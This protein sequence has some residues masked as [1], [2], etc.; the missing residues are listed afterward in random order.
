M[1]T[2]DRADLG[3]SAPLLR[4]AVALDDG[5]GA[6]ER[7][8]PCTSAPRG[9]RGRARRAPVADDVLTPGLEQLRVAAALP[10]LRRHRRCSTDGPQRARRCGSATAGTA[11]GSAG[12][13]G[14]ALYG[15]RARRSSPSWRS[16]RRRAPP[17]RRSPTSTWRAGPSDVARQRPLRRPDDRRAAARRRLAAARR[18]RP[19]GWTGVRGAATIDLRTAGPDVGP[20]VRRQET[21]R[22]ESDVDVAV[23]PH[24]RRLRPEPRRLA[25]LPR[26]RR[27]RRD[28][29]RPAR[30]GAR[31]RRAG[32]PAA[33]R[34]PR[35]PTRSSS[36]AADD[37]FE[38]TF[39]FH[40]FRYAEVDGWPGELTA[41]D[42]EAVV[43]HSDLRAHRHTSRAPTPLLN[44][45]HENVVWS[46]RGNFLDVPTDC[47]QRD[48]RL[49]WTGDIAVFAP[50]AAYLYDVRRLP[51]RLA[52]RPRRRAG[53]RRRARAV[54]RPRRAQVRQAAPRRTCPRRARRSGATPRSWVPWALWQAYGDRDRPGP[55]AP[56]RWL[57]HVR[58]VASPAVGHGPVGAP[59]SSSATGSTRTPRRTA[60]PRRR[61]T[62]PSSRPRA[63]TARARIVAE[64]AEVL[65]RAPRRGEFGDARASGP[66]A[67]FAEHYVD[68]D[69][70]IRSDCTDRLRARDRA[71]GCSTAT[72][73]PR[74]GDRLAELVAED[75]YRDR[76]RLRRHPVRPRRAHRHRARRRLAYRLLLQ[77]GVPVVALPG[78]DGRDDDL[79][80]V[81]LDAARRHASTPA[82]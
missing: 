75:G 31:G 35:R 6:V 10:H 5:H 29:H 42:V 57:A 30:R 44:R 71:S 67:A 59:A 37:A 27:A 48:E 39:T 26:P 28:D 43:V 49:G 41:D 45:L 17:G 18:R 51:R 61:P 14:R 70:A 4:T 24:A 13:G 68:A 9:V 62:R 32:H 77:T 54:R 16:L 46:M 34:R 65:G 64:A 66:R 38:P 79:G 72:P 7:G 19:P 22:A 12:T 76:D 53:R 55:P 20:P 56:D 36:A 21:L 25:A 40:G 78:H 69:G 47:P 11:A 63:S 1:I 2:P 33:A 23:R 8:R 60:P 52:G 58:H 3:S 50:T 81:G 73:A 82:R 15:D 80:A 74:P